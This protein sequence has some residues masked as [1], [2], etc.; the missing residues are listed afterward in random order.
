MTGARW[1]VKGHT[2]HIFGTNMSSP[3]HL[4][5]DL[6]SPQGRKR[7][8]EIT[9]EQLL[10]SLGILGQ[11]FQSHDCDPPPGKTWHEFDLDIAQYDK[12]PLV[13]E[14]IQLDIVKMQ[15]RNFVR[16]PI[17]YHDSMIRVE[18]DGICIRIGLRFDPE[19]SKRFPY[20]MIFFDYCGW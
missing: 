3:E 11:G 4:H 13:L 17:H 7:L 12:L 2:G 16:V 9:G 5:I 6:A 14:Q 15:V 20:G 1:M 8:L 10:D 19:N 18:R